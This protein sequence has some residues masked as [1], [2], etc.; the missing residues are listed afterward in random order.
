MNFRVP[1]VVLLLLSAIAILAPLAY[2]TPPDPTWVAGF[3]DDADHDDIIILITSTLGAVEAH[4]ACD[5]TPA[6]VVVGA[7][8]HNDERLVSSEALSSPQPRAPPVS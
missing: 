2:A 8:P 6:R 4:P 1:V 5:G 7:R 3:W